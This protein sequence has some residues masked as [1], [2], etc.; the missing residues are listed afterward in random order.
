MDCEWLL[1]KTACCAAAFS[2][3]VKLHADP[4]RT[5]VSKGRPHVLLLAKFCG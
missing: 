2:L 4:G 5:N 1:A 3:L